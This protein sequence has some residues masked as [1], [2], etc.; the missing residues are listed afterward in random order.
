M[1][2]YLITYYGG[3]RPESPEAQAKVMDAWNAW[4]AQLGSAVVD[5]GNPTSQS[6]AIS[7]DGSVMDATMAPTGYSI[8]KADSLDE[9]VEAAKG[10]P[11]L[12]DKDAS[13]VVSETLAAM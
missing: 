5:G 1:A 10:C 12:A 13:V 3:G 9:A 6:R 2:N 7:S 8:L 11:V 4:F